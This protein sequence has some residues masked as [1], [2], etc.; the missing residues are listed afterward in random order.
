MIP[1]ILVVKATFFALW[2]LMERLSKLRILAQMG[3][4]SI[5]RK[6][7]A[8]K[9]LHVFATH[10]LTILN[11][12]LLDDL[13]ILTILSA[14]IIF[15]VHK[16]LMALTFRQVILARIVTSILRRERVEKITHV[17]HSNALML[18]DTLT[19]K[20]RHVCV[21]IYVLRYLMVVLSKLNILVAMEER[22]IQNLKN[23]LHSTNAPQIKTPPQLCLLIALLK[24]IILNAQTLEDLKNQMMRLV[25]NI[26]FAP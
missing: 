18:E 8:K 20:I 10:H 23:V 24:K 5:L 25:L 4:N 17:Q 13:M 7:T 22:L 12:R 15:C 26:F 11:V 9:T 16:C 6:V 3:K 1:M 19:L 21:I 14:P 2:C